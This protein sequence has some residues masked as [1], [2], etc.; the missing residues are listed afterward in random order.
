MFLF[1]LYEREGETDREPKFRGGE[2]GEGEG[3]N[4]KQAPCP[5]WGLTLGSSPRPPDGDPR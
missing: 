5:E 2:E 1:L 4:P 3:E